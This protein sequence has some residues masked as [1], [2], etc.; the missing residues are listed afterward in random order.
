[1]HPVQCFADVPKFRTA[2]PI[3]HVIRTSFILMTCSREVLAKQ[4]HHSQNTPKM[5]RMVSW[6]VGSGNW[7]PRFRP[8][9]GS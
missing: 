7:R 2:I 9:G 5:E 6:A 8:T 1:M 3:R 4:L